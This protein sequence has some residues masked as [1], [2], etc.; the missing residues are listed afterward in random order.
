MKQNF[1][2]FFLGLLVLIVASFGVYYFTVNNSGSVSKNSAMVIIANFDKV[3]GL[4]PGSSVKISGID[5]GHVKSLELKKS[6]FEATVSMVID[7]DLL[8]PFDTEAVVE[9][10]GIFGET[11]ITLLPGGSENY[12]KSGDE[13]VLTQGATT[14]LSL[15]SAFSK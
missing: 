3:N 5:V 8:I 1:F 7:K 14:L 10:D 11:F 13:I 12:L 15:L 6:S 4:K 2:E 9:M